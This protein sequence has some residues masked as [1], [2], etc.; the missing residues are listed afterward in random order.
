MLCALALLASCGS[1]KDKNCDENPL[2]D[3]TLRDKNWHNLDESDLA[4]RRVPEIPVRAVEFESDSKKAVLLGLDGADWRFIEPMMKAGILPNLKKLL[5]ESAAGVLKTDLGFSPTTWTTIATGREAADHQVAP[6][7]DFPWDLVHQEPKEIKVRRIWEIAREAGKKIAVYD[8]FFARSRDPGDWG[9]IHHGPIDKNTTLPSGT[10]LASC[11]AFKT[12]YQYQHVQAFLMR[13][14][15]SDLTIMLAKQTDNAAHNGNLQWYKRWRPEMFVEDPAVPPYEGEDILTKTWKQADALIG[16]VMNNLPDGAHLVICS[17]HGFAAPYGDSMEIKLGSCVLETLA[18][19]RKDLQGNCFLKTKTPFGNL[20]IRKNWEVD[21]LPVAHF[22]NRE[23]PERTTAYYE[24][25]QVTCSDFFSH[26]CPDKIEEKLTEALGDEFDKIKI[27]HE[28]R[29]RLTVSVHPDFPDKMIG[30]YVPTTSICAAAVVAQT[31]GHG[32]GDDGIVLLYGPKIKP[33]MIF[34]GATVHDITPTLLYLMGMPVARDFDGKVLVDAIKPTA[35]LSKPIRFVD[36]FETSPII[37]DDIAH[38][39]WNEKTSNLD[40]KELQ[41][42]KSL[43]Y[44]Q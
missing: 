19:S 41:R 3:S 15:S 38:A 28:G 20:E 25:L 4:P 9:W 43:G 1:D 34:S 11:K 44:I 26:G 18:I 32:P 2:S 37:R 16:E 35:L 36:T 39:G 6:Q 31:G 40:E 14:M 7:Y 12:D 5:A 27:T 8:Y 13:Q 29:G 42:L 30:S 22:K 10:S 33:G 23:N 24:K 17:D 21:E